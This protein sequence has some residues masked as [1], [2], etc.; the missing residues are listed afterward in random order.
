MCP[1]SPSRRVHAADR[2]AQPESVG[3]TLVRFEMTQPAVGASLLMVQRG[4][5]YPC[6]PDMVLRASAREKCGGCSRLPRAG[7]DR[8]GDWDDRGG[9]TSPRRPR[10]GPRPS[11]SLP[12]SASTQTQHPLR[13][14]FAAESR[15][16]SRGG[17]EGSGAELGREADSISESRC[18]WR[19]RHGRSGP[20]G[21]APALAASPRPI[22]GC[23][24]RETR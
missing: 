15:S 21:H 18:R 19:S 14:A 9:E 4:Q 2:T 7:R 3:S 12:R 22:W 1:L 6:D 5:E 23:A 10:R 13:Q 24:V 20:G 8:A 17:I 11:S 16:W